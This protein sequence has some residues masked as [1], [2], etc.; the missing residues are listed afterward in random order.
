MTRFDR[1]TDA[2]KGQPALQR[3]ARQASLSLVVRMGE[4]ATTVH[5][6]DSITTTPGAP[7]DAAFTL[8]ATAET[9]AEYAEPVPP[10]GYQSLVGMVRMGHLR[11][12]GD[13]LVFGRNLLFLEQL[14]A[15]LRPAAPVEPSHDTLFTSGTLGRY[16]SGLRDLEEHQKNQVATTAAD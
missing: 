12:E 10:V 15:A 14:F 9:W 2:L 7:F 16:S 1:L 4:E 11:V 13:M 5:I 3:R 6:G 8:I